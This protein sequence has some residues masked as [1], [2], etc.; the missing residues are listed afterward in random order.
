[1]RFKVDRQSELQHYL[2][3]T[4]NNLSYFLWTVGR[5]GEL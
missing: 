3:K 2:T 5:G 4:D 1:M